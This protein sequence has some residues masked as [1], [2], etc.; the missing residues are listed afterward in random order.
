MIRDIPR[1]VQIL[2]L[3]LLAVLLGAGI[4]WQLATVI[5]RISGLAIGYISAAIGGAICF[6]WFVFQGLCLLS[7][8]LGAFRPQPNESKVPAQ[9]KLRWARRK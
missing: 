4:G 6:G 8:F 7:E 5:E 9:P 3:F 1:S 2:L